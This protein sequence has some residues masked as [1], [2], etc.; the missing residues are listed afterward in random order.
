MPISLAMACTQMKMPPVEAITAVTINA[1]YRV[2]RGSQIG[3]LERGKRAD[4][5]VYDWRDYVELSYFS[6]VQL[7]KTVYVEGQSV[8]ES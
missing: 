6:G 8:F 5:V 3:S 2:A 7:A 1:A 4:F